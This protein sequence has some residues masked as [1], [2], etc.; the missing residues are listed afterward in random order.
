MYYCLLFVHFFSTGLIGPRNKLNKLLSFFKA[1]FPV[2]TLKALLISMLLGP[3]PEHI[4]FHGSQ[5]LS[6]PGAKWALG[7]MTRDGAAR[8]PKSLVACRINSRE[9][10]GN[11]CRCSK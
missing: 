4:T 7:L 5:S 3:Q 9:C 1:L 10:E 8:R 11:I 2:C 6:Q